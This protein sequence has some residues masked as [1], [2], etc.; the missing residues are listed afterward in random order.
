MIRQEADHPIPKGRASARRAR[1]PDPRGTRALALERVPEL[2]LLQEC[3]RASFIC[4]MLGVLQDDAMP[5]AAEIYHHPTTDPSTRSTIEHNVLPGDMD[6]ILS[7]APK[8]HRQ[9]PWRDPE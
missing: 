6:Y 1:G 9:A 3:G 8:T 5:L 4:F 2:I 7:H